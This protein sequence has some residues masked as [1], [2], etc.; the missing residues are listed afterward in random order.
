MKTA[1]Q[2]MEA[3]LRRHPVDFAGLYVPTQQGKIDVA[4][5]AFAK[6]YKNN[7]LVGD[8]L[9]PTVEVQNQSDKYWIYG[10]E[11]QQV[12]ADSDLRAPA[13]SAGRIVQTVSNTNYSIVDHS[14]ARLIPDEERGNFQLGD[15]EQWATQYVTDKLAL[16]KEVRVAGIAT[17]LANYAATNR[18]TLAGTTQWSDFVN[19]DPGTDME[20]AKQQLRKAGINSGLKLLIGDDVFVKLRRH[21]KILQAM[22][23]AAGPGALRPVSAQDLAAY[24]GIDEVIVGSSI[25]LNAA[26]TPSFVWGKHAV[27]FFNQPTTSMQD[28]SFGKAFQWVN[29]PGTTGGYSTQID[30]VSPG[31]AKADELHVH[32]YY[33]LAITSNISAYFFQNAVA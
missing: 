9:F 13:A 27:L 7:L 23:Y 12:Y 10:R 4:L 22:T 30:R 3:M 17:T 1:Q 8:Q 31:S 32:W 5:S 29:A 2:L 18:V 20:T 26:G 25:T 15:V 21:T 28:P 6:G 11:N 14:L 19:S 24:F 16:L 33:G